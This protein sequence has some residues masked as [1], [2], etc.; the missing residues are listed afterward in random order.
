MKKAIAAM[1]IAAAMI[2][3]T[4]QAAPISGASRA[5]ADGQKEANLRAPIADW[6]QRILDQLNEPEPKEKKRTEKHYIYSNE[7]TLNRRNGVFY[8]P[9]GK[10]SYY[11]LPMAR[12]VSYMRTLEYRYPYWVR[13][14]GVKMLGDYVMVAADLKIRP[15]G[16][17][18]Q[19][20]LG[21]GIV[22]DT[23]T[24]VAQDPTALD[25]AVDWR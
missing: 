14:D 15:K 2:P 3:T 11:N 25:I 12:V 23:G 18:L 1:L 7:N 21:P 5:L 13:N 20:S 19:T 24:F 6:Q 22:C 10:E 4:A 16:T 8:G 17:I 9:S